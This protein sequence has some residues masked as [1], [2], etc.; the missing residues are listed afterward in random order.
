LTVSLILVFALLLIPFFG[1]MSGR[2]KRSP[3]LLGFWA[4]WLLVAH[5]LDV[6]YLIMPQ[7]QPTGVPV[8]WID[9]C[10]MAGAGAVFVAGILLLAGCRSLTPTQDPRLGESLGFENI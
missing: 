5:W 4:A 9:A 1:L 10:C 8:A 2:V 3:A 7:V 6:H